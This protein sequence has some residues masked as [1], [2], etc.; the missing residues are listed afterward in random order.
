MIPDANVYSDDEL[1]SILTTARDEYEVQTKDKSPSI[2][3]E[4]LGV[5]N[6]WEAEEKMLKLIS[7]HISENG[8]FKN[9]ELLENIVLWKF[10]PAVGNIRDLSTDRVYEESERAFTANTASEA[11]SVLSELDGIAASMAGAVLTFAN[12]DRYT[13]MD[14]RATTAL[15][16]LGYW[17]SPC[18]A[19]VDLYETYCLRSHQLSQQT[20]LPLRAVDRALYIIND[21][22]AQDYLK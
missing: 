22:G 3:T 8:G 11:M 16:S 1:R 18:E 2:L 10:A 6:F 13:V 5:E 21:D 12:P 17:N 7:A 19:S 9:R 15:T 14:P 4:N 20:D